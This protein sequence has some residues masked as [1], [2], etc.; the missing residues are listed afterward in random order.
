MRVIAGA[1][2]TVF[3]I[4]VQL[5]HQL[6]LLDTDAI[7]SEWVVAC[8]DANWG[9]IRWAELTV[10]DACTDRGG[11]N[12]PWGTLVLSNVIVVVI[13]SAFLT[14]CTPYSILIGQSFICLGCRDADKIEP[15][16]CKWWIQLLALVKR[17]WHKA[18]ICTVVDD[19]FCCIPDAEA[20]RCVVDVVAINGREEWWI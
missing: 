8:L 11:P 12:H 7:A 20:T 9:Q 4:W 3:A 17:V 18:I 14:V 2:N 15:V 13:W 6:E 19:Y 5:L 1:W 10:A 16:C